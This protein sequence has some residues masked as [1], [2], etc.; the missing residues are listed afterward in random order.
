[1]TL[2]A[3]LFAAAGPLVANVLIGLGFATVTFTG[4]NLLLNGV[5]DNVK[6]N[7]ANVPVDLLVFLNMG[8]IPD[9]F[10]ILLGA[11]S[12]RLALMS[13]KRFRMANP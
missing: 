2:I 5:I 1:M 4:I 6:L 12:A 3:W 8:G 9:A 7:F 13:L 10:S 11:L